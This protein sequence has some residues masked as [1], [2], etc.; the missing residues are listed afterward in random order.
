MNSED[1]SVRLTT[2]F[3]RFFDKFHLLKKCTSS[4]GPDQDF[5]AAKEMKLRFTTVLRDTM[6][7]CRTDAKLCFMLLTLWD[8]FLDLMASAPTTFLV[9]TLDIDLAWQ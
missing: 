9:P 3:N 7:M 4:V 6:R 5:S 2:V 8:R 1:S